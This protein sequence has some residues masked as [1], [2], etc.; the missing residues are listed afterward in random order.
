MKYF[1]ISV[2]IVS[3]FTLS[4]FGADE[5]PI[6]KVAS[7]VGKSW[8]LWGGHKEALHLGSELF[9]GEMIMTESASEVT[10]L[11][12]H[13]VAA[14]LKGN[15]Q[16]QVDQVN[17]KDWSL[18]LHQGSVLSSV[19]NPEHRPN[20]FQVRTHAAVMGVRGT[21]FFVKT[22][23]DGGVFLCTCHGTVAVTSAHG[24]QKEFVITSQHH[25]SPKNIVDGSNDVE[26]RM[27][28]APVGSD[29]VDAEAVALEK[30][31][32]LS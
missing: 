3:C 8:G 13:E 30:L 26:S 18:T 10:L 7:L 4:A 12:A 32:N 11:I 6:G 19:R 16:A 15:S 20:H 1:A 17:G 9:S 24:V 5:T 28:A 25:D 31:L 22:G 23:S 14:L 27:K 2:L 21:T 29:H